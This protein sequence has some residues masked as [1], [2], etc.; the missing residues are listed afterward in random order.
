MAKKDKDTTTDPAEATADTPLQ[1][2][3]DT[4]VMASVRKDG[5]PDQSPDFVF[6]NPAVGEKLLAAQQADVADPNKDH[7]AMLRE[8]ARDRAAEAAEG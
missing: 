7:V 1:R 3:G 8:E 5:T 4:V 6:H 2:V